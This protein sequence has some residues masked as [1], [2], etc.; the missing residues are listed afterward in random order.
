[1]NRPRPLR[2]GTVA[3]GALLAVAAL[4]GP[5]LASTASAAAPAHPLGNFTVNHYEG[6]VVAPGKLTVDH[7]EDLAEIPAT[8]ARAA[9]MTADERSAWA[10]ERCR[11][12]ARDSTVTAA[13]RPAALTV[14][15]GSAQV[16]PGQAGLVTLRLECLL[17]APLPD[18]AELAVDFHAPARHG[19]GWREITARADRMTL[20]AASV[21]TRSVSDRL[22]RY[23]AGLLSSPPDRTSAELR[24]AP[25]GPPL[26]TDSP[27]PAATGVLPRGADRWTRA[28]TG[29]VARRDLTAGFAALALGTALLLGALHALAP[30]HGKT[31]MAAA[32]AAGGRG[33]L[34]QVLALGASVTL[35]HT[36]GVFALGGLIAAGS[37]AT[38]SVVS[39]LGVVS[40][41]LVAGA[42]T[43][44][45]R[46][47]WRNRRHQKEHPHGHGHSHESNSPHTHGHSH[48]HDDH[49]HDH[50]RPVGLRGTVLLGFA[51]GLV[52]S[53]SAVVVLVGAAALGQAWFGALLVLAYGAGLALTLTA[54]G[55]AAVRIGERLVRLGRTRTRGRLAAAANRFA[56]LGTAFVV[57]FLG[58]GLVLK[59][60]A[61]ALG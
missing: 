3:G 22:V 60:A 20:K 41:A 59:G 40:G 10:A 44:L 18:A 39:W 26:A 49:H 47:A 14:E 53:P 7:V 29:L 36:L 11:A 45:V 5:L 48:P 35:T 58:C 46:R 56:P 6:L 30:G 51:G 27:G 19:P 50:H 25:G 12:A 28:L 17:A 8:Q 15:S 31:M 42:G 37:A 43:V 4:V 38:P 54:A 21:P 9:E 33:S 32:A 34:R 55:Y 16:R 23:P 13:G 57:L 24:A 2:L 61:A 1:M 52:P